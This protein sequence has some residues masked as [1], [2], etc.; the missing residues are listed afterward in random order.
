MVEKRLRNHILE[1]KL[2]CV[3]E[4]CNAVLKQIFLTRLTKYQLKEN[5]KAVTD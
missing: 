3:Y 2:G 5:E 4:Y 1:N